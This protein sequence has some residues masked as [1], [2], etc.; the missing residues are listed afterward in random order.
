MLVF[1]SSH[2]FISSCTQARLVP[3]IHFFLWSSLVKT[4]IQ[5]FHHT[6]THS[7]SVLLFFI[8][9][10]VYIYT[11]RD[12]NGMST[13]SVGGSGGG[14]TS[15]KQ[16]E[17]SAAVG[18]GGSGTTSSVG[19]EHWPQFEPTQQRYL[20]LGNCVKCIPHVSCCLW[21]WLYVRIYIC[22]CG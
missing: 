14:G 2:S 22:D 12:P 18:G 19:I 16:D 20:M 8:L 10:I 1:L 21:S 17:R 6:H 5:P 13:V 9:T 7:F 11:Y 3:L 4:R 15:P